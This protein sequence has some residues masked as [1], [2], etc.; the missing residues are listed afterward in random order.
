MLNIIFYKQIHIWLPNIIIININ[1]LQLRKL[2]NVD[3]LPILF[4]YIVKI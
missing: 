4:G 2:C 1:T 3:N